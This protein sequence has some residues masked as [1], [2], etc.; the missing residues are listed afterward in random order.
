MILDG[1]PLQ[2]F[3]LIGSPVAALFMDGELLINNC[4]IAVE[5][6]GKA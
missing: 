6:N 5:P 2:D 3:R 4:G 1:D